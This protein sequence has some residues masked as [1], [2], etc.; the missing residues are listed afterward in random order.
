MTY[1]FSTR[2]GGWCLSPGDFRLPF[3]SKGF[4]G[5]GSSQSGPRAPAHKYSTIASA[6]PNRIILLP[7]S[8]TPGITYQSMLT[9]AF[10]CF[11]GVLL[12]RIC[13]LVSKWVKGWLTGMKHTWGTEWGIWLRI[14]DT[15]VTFPTIRW[16]YQSQEIRTSYI[17]SKRYPWQ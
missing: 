5:S 16:W 9:S 17:P 3:T 11:I 6:F 14:S 12:M 15:G 10:I 1:L 4:E 13:N 7:A 2:S 8:V